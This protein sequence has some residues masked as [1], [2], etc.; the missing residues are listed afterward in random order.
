MN[1]I[2]N[3]CIFAFLK[4]K[5]MINIF[6]QNNNQYIS[7]EYGIQL[8]DIIKN[9]N[10]QEKL[11]FIGA[12][13]NNQIRSLQYHIHKPSIINFFNLTSE[14]G[15][16]MYLRSVY[17]VLF[18][19]VHDIYPQADLIISHSIS[20]GKYCELDNLDEPLS[21]SVVDKI[22]KRM[23]EIIASNYPIERKEVETAEALSMY[24]KLGLSPKSD[25]F[26]NRK[27]IFTTIYQLDDVVN[28]YYGPL[29]PSTSFIYLYRVELYETGLLLK[30]PSRKNIEHISNTRKMPKLFATY[31]EFKK[32]A[33][34]MGVPYVSD[35]NHQVENNNIQNMILMTEALQ[36]KKLSAIAD[37]I[38]RKDAKI[39][40]IS[41]P[42]SSGKTTTCK[43]LSIQ[44]GIL[45]YSPVQ[46]SV[47]DFFVEREDTPLDENGE[48][49][50][51]SIDAIDIDLFNNVLK[52]LLEGKEV[53]IPTFN[54]TI[55]KK[56]W[57]GNKLQMK[58]NSILVIEGIHCLNP[59][60]TEHI[61][62]SIKF[63]IFVSA[64]TSLS[65]DKQNPIPT[66]DNRL[67]RRIIR[68]YQYRGY[69][70]ADTINRWASVRKG[71]ENNI[72]PYQENADVMYNTSLVYELGVFLKY[73]IPILIEVPETSPEYVEAARLIKFLT[74]FKAIPETM[75]PGNSILREFV[76]GSKFKY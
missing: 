57:K 2:T 75:I 21:Q 44:L 9:E 4:R 63:K 41:G 32:W 53:D 60:L 10:L 72:F 61:D 56:E 38:K 11:P 36:E 65:I 51:E 13:V 18:K 70:A 3:F 47:D 59:K 55:G 29:L 15:H 46:I 8:S 26:R 37:E 48:K 45:D 34:T 12:L 69:S 17:F 64:L 7:V 24:Q 19:A 28:Y 58:P 31:R 33:N 50:Y 40:L 6:C 25:I 35:I 20:G 42:S 54:F 43:R 30:I 49:D 39:V 66:S 62:N 22:H 16:A 52:D 67:I 23:D 5:S 14:Y 73:A 1:C 27:R 74:Y 76:G 68:D 71:E